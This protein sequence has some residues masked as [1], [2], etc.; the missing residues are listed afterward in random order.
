MSNKWLAP[1]KIILPD[2]VICGAMKCGTSTL[3]AMLNQ[4]PD[5]FIPKKEVHFFDLDNPLQ[6]AD[7]NFFND[8]NWQTHDLNKNSG[9]YWQWYSQQF[10]SAKKGQV[11]GEDSTTYLASPLAAKRISMQNK[12]IKLIVM[13]RQPSK[14]A[15]SQYWHLVRSGRAIYNFED[16]LQLNPN[17]VLNR[18][19]YLT[20][21]KSLLEYIPKT[22]IKFVV[23]ED[24]LNNKNAVLKEVCEFLNVSFD[25]L[26]LNVEQ[27]HENITTYPK[28][29]Q[30][31]LLKNSV[32]P[33]AGNLSYQTQFQLPEQLSKQSKSPL[34]LRY[35]NA[36][37]RKINPLVTKK[38]VTMSINTKRFL[39]DFFI[40][41]LDGLNELIEYD[42]NSLWFT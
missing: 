11:I 34:F 2:F 36:F 4:H 26:P 29:Y 28:Y 39:D 17:S 24:F 20:Q 16:T 23:F 27:V 33:R 32:F 13:L 31:Q 15:Y 35:I 30:L 10:S 1:S 21:I 18:S 38:P 6:H 5:I 19:M 42:I 7:F 12:E 41:E 25:R 14:R 8:S 22:S 3:H 37:H 9:E 40:S